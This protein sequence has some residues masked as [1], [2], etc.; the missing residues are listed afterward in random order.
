[1]N[2]G[3]YGNQV[4]WEQHYKKTPGERFDWLLSFESLKPILTSYI[5]SVSSTILYVGCGTSELADKLCDLGYTN[6]TCIDFSK[7][8]I[9]QQTEYSKKKE[10]QGKSVPNFQFMDVMHMDFEPG[11]FDVVIDKCTVDSILSGEDYLRK[12]LKTLREISR[13]LKEDG[14]YLMFSHE[15]PSKRIY[16]LKNRLTKFS[17]VEYFPV[18]R[19]ETVKLQSNKHLN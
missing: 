11:N 7:E 6:I 18:N 16:Y 2:S 1:M 15:S 4:Y 12:C 5:P 13:V 17:R 14:V 3:S 9:K 10:K 8:A 19:F